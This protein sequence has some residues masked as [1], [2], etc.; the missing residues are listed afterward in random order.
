MSEWPRLT[1][2]HR[3]FSPAARCRKCGHPI[4]MVDFIGWV[5]TTPPV[6]GGLYDFCTA[7]HGA[8]VPE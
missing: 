2:Q 3:P 7:G 4:R 1:V 5:D 8:H 6:Y